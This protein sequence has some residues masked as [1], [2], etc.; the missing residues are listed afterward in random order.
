MHEETCAVLFTCS[1][2]PSPEEAEISEAPYVKTA[3][4]GM[5]SSG[6]C[7]LLLRV[8][9]FHLSKNK[10]KNNKKGF[11]ALSSAAA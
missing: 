3:G 7:Q 9:L 1:L 6:L 10:N 8:F 2:S 4:E 5:H 11:R